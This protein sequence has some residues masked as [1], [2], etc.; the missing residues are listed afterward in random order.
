MKR[1]AYSIS[2]GF[3]ALALSYVIFVLTALACNWMYEAL[4]E[5]FPDVFKDYGPFQFEERER[6]RT[7]ITICGS[8][9]AILLSAITV[10]RLDNSRDEQI[11]KETE[12]FYKIK[13]MLPSYYKK[14]AV[15]DLISAILTT[16]FISA[17]IIPAYLIK[18]SEASSLSNFLKNFRGF[19]VGIFF[20]KCGYA[21]APL[22]I[23][24]ITYASKMLSALSGLK[25]WRA[26]WLT[27]N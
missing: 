18:F 1:Y 15:P 14:Y 10:T 5:W 9:L 7:V 26:A 19:H 25:R 22:V 23:F 11:I 12:G 8:S 21:I 6:V 17:L 20:D 2:Y 4:I 24:A 16:A 27:Y 13:D 3:A